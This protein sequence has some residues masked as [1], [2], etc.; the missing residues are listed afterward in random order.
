VP[1]ATNQLRV[2]SVPIGAGG[3]IGADEPTAPNGHYGT[4]G[5]HCGG[6]SCRYQV[7]PWRHCTSARV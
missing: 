5:G 2:A 3:I 6:E 7:L 4:G 1:L